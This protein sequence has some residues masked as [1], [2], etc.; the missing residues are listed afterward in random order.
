VIGV[1]PEVVE[2]LDVVRVVVVVELREGATRDDVAAALLRRR[3]SPVGRV[4]A[5]EVPL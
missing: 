4:I 1:R 2:P 5:C 3:L